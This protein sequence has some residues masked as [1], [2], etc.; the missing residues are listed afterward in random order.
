MNQ[1]CN[2][3]P[4]L[5]AP[6]SRLTLGKLCSACLILLTL[7]FAA[8]LAQ[9]NPDDDYLNIYSIILRADQQAANGEAAL[10]H[11]NYLTAQTDL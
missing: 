2:L 8:S 7:L 9:A 10:A 4:A 6:F 1:P 3:R 11:T 5:A